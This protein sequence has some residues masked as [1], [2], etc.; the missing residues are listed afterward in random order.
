ML[1]DIGHRGKR[2]GRAEGY[3]PI[4]VVRKAAYSR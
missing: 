2:A 3:A 4:T 1:S